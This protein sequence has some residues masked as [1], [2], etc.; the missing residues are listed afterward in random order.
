MSH[1]IREPETNRLLG[2]LSA[3]D[4]AHLA[5]FSHIEHPPQGRVL[6]GSSDPGTDIWF[7]HAGAVALITTDAAGR[8]VQTGMVGREGCLGLESVFGTRRTAPEAV[9]QIAGPM[10][11]IPATHLRTVLAS[12][13][14]V[15]VAISKFLCGLSAQSFQTIACN[16]L[17]SL[18]MR[19]CRWLLT[20][21]D[22][23][24]SEYLPV[25]QENLAILL[26]G[27]RP[28]VNL[29][30]AELEQEGI[31]RRHRGRLQILSRE[32]LERQSC[33]CY[34]LIRDRSASL[35]ANQA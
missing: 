3:E 6:S 16:R 20:L 21:Q 15:Q 18:R 14:R 13:P 34:R 23:A 35:Y 12:R 9:V 19:C 25:T 26:G 2:I 22:K 33:E 31:L 17:H 28:R 27:G 29:L 24:M 32:G 11:V 10:S 7:P 8:S 4:S 1:S 30:L 5:S